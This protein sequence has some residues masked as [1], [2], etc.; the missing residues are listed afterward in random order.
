MRNALL[1]SFFTLFFYGC[2]TAQ[3]P[4]SSSNKK[5]IHYFEL[6]EKAPKEGM[7]PM[8]G[9]YDFKS[10]IELL[11]KALEK[12]SNFWEAHI[13]DAEFNEF[14]RNYKQ[15]I[16]HYKR[17]LE[18]DANHSV[19]GSSTY[20]LATCQMAV[21]DYEGALK[22][23]SIYLKNPNAKEENLGAVRRM[24]DCANF[25]IQAMKNPKPFE[26]KN[27]GASIN[28]NFSEYYPTITVDGHT[29]LFTRRLVD[30]QGENKREQEDFYVSHQIDRVWSRSY[31][32]PKNVNTPYNEGAPSIS[33]DGKKLIF[34]ACTDESG[35]DYG[36][37]RQG[38]GSCDLFITEQNG[39]SWSNPINLPGKVNST[40]WETQPSLSADGKTLYFI[41]GLRS[42]DGK[43]DSDIYVSH[44]LNDGSW[45]TAEPLPPH[46]NS[47]QNEE[48]VLIHPDGKTLYFA[49]RGHVGMGGSDLYVSR[50]DA[51]GNW[52]L[53][54]NL[55]YPINTL[56]DENSLMVSPEGDIAYF[57]SDRP[58][59]YGLMDIYYFNLPKEDQPI[60]TLYFDGFV[61]DAKTKK[62][63][64]A[65]FQLTNLSTGQ[66]VIQSKADAADG[67]FMVALP[68]NTDY[69]IEVNYP[70]YLPYSLN[71]NMTLKE[72]EQSYHLQIPLNPENS[73]S[74]NILSNV[75][76]DLNQA[77][78]R[79]ESI[80][81]LSSFAN[82]L[83]AHP[84]LKIEIGGHTD[85]RGN[86]QDN[87]T[88]STNRAKAVKDF[89]LS[90]G[91]PETQLTSK[92]YGS[93]SPIMTDEA[94][95]AISDINE[96]E[97]AHQ[98]NRRTTYTLK[99]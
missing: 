56:S 12:D 67:T 63:L 51:K 19:S 99:P 38:K 60:K 24:Q 84:N 15:S 95:N 26:P 81:E 55:G 16:F 85:S 39:K 74:E 72:N 44:L 68:V 86:A 91:I 96:K 52:G 77:K 54:Q 75:F 94:I 20:H 88:L 90:K 47:N 57:A 82:Y 64:G 1:F 31:P 92:G 93:A 36:A 62:S 79:P 49:S 13:L 53:P 3:F 35:V 40:H 98:K 33:P 28:T 61:F 25:A 87:L 42:R 65:S 69:A 41:R 6:A 43:R 59:G 76:F 17:A 4:Y 11:G 34:V 50:M 89:L 71:F 80:V 7:D 5:A 32:M 22:S 70:G 83:K 23:C 18:I 45:S 48:S 46:I 78:L 21:A 10:G 29:M 37:N 73:S 2:S 9:A 14:I 97:K 8:T 58:G 66:M 27:I 30:F